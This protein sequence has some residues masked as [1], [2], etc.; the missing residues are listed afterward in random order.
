VRYN[1]PSPK[2]LKS[3]WRH[4]FPLYRE[5]QFLVNRPGFLLGLYE[6]WLFTANVCRLF[7]EGI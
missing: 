4:F 2:Q 1:L 7:R 5:R 6:L 3:E